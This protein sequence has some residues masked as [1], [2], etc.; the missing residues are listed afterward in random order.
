MEQN[1]QDNLTALGT[2]SKSGTSLSRKAVGGYLKAAGYLMFKARRKPYLTKKNKEARLRWA[3]EHLGWTLEDW[4]QVIWTDEATYKTGLDS[5]IC[6][7][8]RKPGTSMDSRY[9]K[10][11]F[12]SGR[13]TLGIW[14]AIA[15][16]KKA[17]VHFLIKVV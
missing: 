10:S 12:K 4:M 6:Y 1:I 15:L 9:L 13:T 2:P 3:R 11:R 5:R 8:T 7:V 16:G 17:P 14:G